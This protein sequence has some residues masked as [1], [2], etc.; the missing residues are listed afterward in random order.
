MPSTRAR[1]RARQFSIYVDVPVV[2]NLA[3]GVDE[4]RKAVRTN[5]KHGANFIKIL[6]TG[7]VLSK[8][9]SPGAQQYSEDELR[10]AVEEANRWGRY[11][12]A[13]A[14]GTGGINAAL[15]AGVR[16]I[17]H[18]TMLDDESI[19]LLKS[20]HAYFVPTLLVGKLIVEKG[21][22]LGV[23]KPE[24]ERQRALGD[25]A[26]ESLAKAMNAGVPVGFGTDAGVFAHGEN[27]R[28]FAVRAKFGD[29]AYRKSDL[30][31]GAGTQSYKPDISIRA[32]PEANGQGT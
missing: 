15:R 9:I 31:P 23:P 5:L 4:V 16:T 20:K 17:D 25:R 3:D 22:S 18:G 29:C 24:I 1:S 2:Q 21:E 26:G 6:A 7:A 12:A 10:V 28:E 30:Q 27:A 19:A 32:S 11:V 14:H 8:G 13:H